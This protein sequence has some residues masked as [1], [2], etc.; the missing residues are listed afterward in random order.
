VNQLQAAGFQV[1][2]LYDTQ[3]TVNVMAT[4]SQ[5]DVVYMHTH[6]DPF[7]GGDGVVATGQLANDDA[8]LATQLQNGTVV[9]VGVSGSNDVYYAITSS[10]IRTYEDQF[11]GNSIIFLNGCGLLN[12]PVF[13]QAL[14]SKGVGVM[15]A[16]DVE[17]TS[18]DNYLSGAA[19]F[20]EM[21]KGLSVA[22]AI[23]AEQAAGYGKSNVNG[24]QATLGFVGDGSITLQA[25]ANSPARAT[26]TPTPPSRQPTSVPTKPAP[27]ST[28]AP[29]PT[30]V[31][32]PPLTVQL[33]YLKIEPG[34]RQVIQIK[35]A[36]DT[37][38]HIHISFPNGDLR[39]DITA[40]DG[41]GNAR[42]GYLQRSSKVMYR[43]RFATVT[44]EAIKDQGVTVKTVKYLIRW[45]KLDVA[46]QPRVQAVDKMIQVWVHTQAHTKVT[47]A[48]F[49][50]RKGSVKRLHGRTG[51]HGWV[52]LYYRV[53]R[54]LKW[55]NDHTVLVRARVVLGSTQQFAE[56]T[57]RII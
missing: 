27:T 20:A 7:G 33:K 55:G 43:N 57:F 35:S 4:L 2:Q 14:A 9:K 25:A 26:S 37:I 41:A 3:V 15:V 18:Q 48:L 30:R 44:V 29:T 52:H 31:P 56:T 23:T 6:S 46:V 16:W 19:F 10:Y 34:T 1:D 12:A 11:P 50:P 49:F 47:V 38:I 36:P 8:A 39:T 45:S 53:G 32:A 40:T 51:R 5:Y 42:Y 21:A 54:Y 24:T 13:W 17:A 28:P 22:A